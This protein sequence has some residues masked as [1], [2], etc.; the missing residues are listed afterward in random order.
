VR[1]CVTTTEGSLTAFFP[2][3]NSNPVMRVVPVV[4]AAPYV[5]SLSNV[6]LAV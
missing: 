1:L 4:P 3:L 2:S 6:P 5:T